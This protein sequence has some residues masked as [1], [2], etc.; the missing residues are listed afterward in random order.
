LSADGTH[1]T[2]T[3]PSRLTLA[4]IVK[5]HFMSCEPKDLYNNFKQSIFALILKQ[6]KQKDIAE[7]LTS[8]TF[9]RICHCQADGKECN[10]PKSYLYR[11]A[12]NLIN[13]Y[14][15]SNKRQIFITSEQLENSIAEEELPNLNK[16]VIECLLPLIHKLP[17]SYKE[18]IILADL[19]QLPQ[20]QI[21]Q[22]LGISISGAKS[23]IQRGRQQLK[24]L[25]LNSC[26]IKT[27]PFGNVTSCTC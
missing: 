9:K 15:N 8:E 20:L 3:T 12:L 2:A 18:A 11:I 1:N 19:Q 22:R 5:R 7:E 6:V 26:Q 4:V 17:P 16:E 21:A 23:R 24:L 13:D 14:F 10:N 27:D 25:L